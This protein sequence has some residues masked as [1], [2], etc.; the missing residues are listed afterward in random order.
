MPQPPRKEYTL[1][2]PVGIYVMLGGLLFGA[3]GCAVTVELTQDRVGGILAFIGMSG[4]GIG[5]GVL[6]ILAGKILEALSNNAAPTR[7]TPDYGAPPGGDSGPRPAPRQQAPERDNEE[8]KDPPR[9][10]LSRRMDE[11]RRRSGNF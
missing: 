8:P 10:G 1:H 3:A 5:V 9:S 2:T 4:I 7:R 6:V 11:I